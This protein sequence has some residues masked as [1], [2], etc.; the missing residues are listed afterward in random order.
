LPAIA[1]FAGSTLI[2]TTELSG[3]PNPFLLSTFGVGVPGDLAHVYVGAD[4]TPPAPPT[5]LR[6]S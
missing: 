4:I 3:A 6:I 5:G 2:T 1:S